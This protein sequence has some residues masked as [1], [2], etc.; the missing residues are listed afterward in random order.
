MNL[1]LKVSWVE[2]KKSSKKTISLRLILQTE[3][4]LNNPSRFPYYI[5][6][7]PINVNNSKKMIDKIVLLIK[8]IFFIYI[9]RIMFGFFLA[10]MWNNKSIS[11]LVKRENLRIENDRK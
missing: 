9:N 4:M 3:Q 6:K 8:I 1:S 11:Y 10:N 2:F 5:R 7:I